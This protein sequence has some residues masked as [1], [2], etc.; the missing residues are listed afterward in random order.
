M[1]KDKYDFI[2]EVLNNHT[3]SSA[4][5][6]RILLL[7]SAEIRRDKEFSNVLEERVIRLE[8]MIG[9]NDGIVLSHN[10]D[11]GIAL[12]RFSDKDLNMLKPNKENNNDYD[13]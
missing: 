11:E 1:A 13:S 2:Q 10:S 6:E 4:Q 7:T 9:I 8:G 5:R 12:N 3:L